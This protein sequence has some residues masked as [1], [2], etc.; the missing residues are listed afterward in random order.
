MKRGFN[1][2]VGL[3]VTLSRVMP[4]YSLAHY[5]RWYCDGKVSEQGSMRGYDMKRHIPTDE[6]LLAFRDAYAPAILSIWQQ[7]T[8]GCISEYY[9]FTLGATPLEMGLEG[10]WRHWAQ[11]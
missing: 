8:K 9:Q 11:L 7:V 3:A 2:L 5:Y 10:A 6:V 1:E 4:R